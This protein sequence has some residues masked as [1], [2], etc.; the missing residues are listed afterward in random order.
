MMI[1]ECQP[2]FSVVFLQVP[3]LDEYLDLGC[4]IPT[5]GR[6]RYYH[7]PEHAHNGYME[8]PLK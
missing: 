1:F 8:I 2:E 5:A 3:L 6:S 4:I 7:P